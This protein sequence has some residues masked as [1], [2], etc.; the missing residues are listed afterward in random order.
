MKNILGHLT[1]KQP[2]L[3][4]AT[5]N[6]NKLILGQQ[7]RC[8]SPTQ[9]AASETSKLCW[10]VAVCQTREPTD[11][12]LVMHQTTECH[13]VDAVLCH[14]TQSHVGFPRQAQLWLPA[15]YS[16]IAVVTSASNDDQ[17]IQ[18]S[19]VVLPSSKCWPQ[20]SFAKKCFTKS[21]QDI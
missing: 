19:F 6:C 9:L 1:D 14:S 18:Q 5:S 15:Q 12:L 7:C 21:M 17:E 2:Y 13:A 20:K 3:Y 10:D 11:C 8:Q 4:L 16:H